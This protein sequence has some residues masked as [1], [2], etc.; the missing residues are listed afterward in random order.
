MERRSLD[1]R[2]PIFSQ[3]PFNVIDLTDDNDVEVAGSTS[4]PATTSN[5]SAANGTSGNSAYVI[6]LESEVSTPHEDAVSFDLDSLEPED[7]QSPEIEII[8]EYHIPQQAGGLL[9]HP[10]SLPRIRD[11][12]ATFPQMNHSNSQPA[13]PATDPP[14]G[15]AVFPGRAALPPPQTNLQRGRTLAQRL[16]QQPSTFLAH[17]GSVARLS[18]LSTWPL[19]YTSTGFVLGGRP[20]VPTEPPTAPIPTYSPPVPA[21]EGFTRSP[22]EGDVLICPNCLDELCVGTGLESKVYVIKACGHVRHAGCA[23]LFPIQVT[24]LTLVLLGLLWRVRKE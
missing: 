19:D 6:D 4:S 13:V 1:N 8:S 10:V 17:L 9:P 3:E 21:Q 12:F 15:R 5:Y 11:L 24:R 2:R 18:G 16:S 23:G 7:S 22:Q 20:P 14:Q